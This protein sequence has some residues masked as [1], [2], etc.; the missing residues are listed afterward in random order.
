MGP[1]LRSEKR[2][3]VQ[4]AAPSPRSALRRVAY[5]VVLASVLVGVAGLAVI[6]ART[7]GGVAGITVADYRATA[8]AEEG[9]APSFRLEILDGGSEIALEDFRGEVVV[10]NFWAS[11]CSPCRR[12]APGLAKVA[13]AHEGPG[14]QFV[15]VNYVDDRAAAK[16]FEDEFELPY[17][18]A[19]DPSGS[20]GDDYRLAGL[21]T[22]FIVD[23]RGQLVYAL[24]GYTSEELLERAIRDVLSGESSA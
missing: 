13:E 19:Y 20:L 21:P 2:A 22:T 14:V 15:G 23:R 11:W 24:V 6:G 1:A 17:P 10:L 16:A 5:G 8:R 4:R 7:R 9:P 3:D 12:E 18:S